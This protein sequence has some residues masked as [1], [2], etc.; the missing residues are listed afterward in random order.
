MFVYER[1]GGWEQNTNNITINQEAKIISTHSAINC[2]GMGPRPLR[3]SL[4][5]MRAS[6]SLV[7]KTYLSCTLHINRSMS[8]L[9][10]DIHPFMQREQ[11]K[12]GID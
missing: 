9:H 6:H 12:S 10:R 7:T 2:E 3:P 8:L 5:R 1:E 11:H 4:M